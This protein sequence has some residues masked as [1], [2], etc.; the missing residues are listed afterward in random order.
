M[1]EKQQEF[2]K[3]ERGDPRPLSFYSV[4]EEYTLFIKENSEQANA[5]IKQFNKEEA[6]LKRYKRSVSEQA[7]L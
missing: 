5:L 7:P 2:E 4:P 6:E 1:I 3:I